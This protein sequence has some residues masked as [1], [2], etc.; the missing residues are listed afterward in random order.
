[1]PN[2][3]KEGITT[4]VFIKCLILVYCLYFVSGDN[5]QGKYYNKFKSL[6]CL[7]FISIILI[8]V[9]LTFFSIYCKI[10]AV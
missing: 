6:H 8:E 3:E 4:F 7:L 1:M 2:P 9:F 5:I 10:L